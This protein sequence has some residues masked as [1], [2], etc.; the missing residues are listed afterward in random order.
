MNWLTEN[1]QIGTEIELPHPQRTDQ[2]RFTATVVNFIL[3]NHRYPTGIIAKFKCDG[4][5]IEIE[6]SYLDESGK[7]M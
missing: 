6:D 4:K 3:T 7:G 5:F 1:Y 2:D